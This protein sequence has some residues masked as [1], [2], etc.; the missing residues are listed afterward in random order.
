MPLDEV[1]KYPGGKV[2]DVTPQFV[3]PGRPEATGRFAVA[4]PDVVAEL[5]EVAAESVEPG[6]YVSSGRV[7]SHLLTS[8]RMREVLNS[9]YHDLP[10]IRRR[11]PYNPAYMNP[12]DLA[13]QGLKSGDRVEI[14]SDHDRIP[15]IVQADNTLRPGVVSMTH[16]WGGMPGEETDFEKE[17]SA[18]NALVSTDH[19]CEPI[20][21]MPRQSAIPVNILPLKPASHS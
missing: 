3:E 4:P 7:F 16:A 15:A 19:H 11:R 5:A 14:V 20:N 10:G 17:G 6:R 18:T 1:K 9:T 21:A 8:R 12:V 2:F 13:A